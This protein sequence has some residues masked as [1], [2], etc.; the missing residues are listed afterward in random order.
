MSVLYVYY[1]TKCGIDTDQYVY[2]VNIRIYIKSNMTN[3]LCNTRKLKG[4]LT[5]RRCALLEKFSFTFCFSLICHS[6]V[7]TDSCL[8]LTFAPPMHGASPFAEY[9]LRYFF[10]N[11]RS[12]FTSSSL[13]KH[14][15]YQI[16]WDF[17]F[18]PWLNF[19][20]EERVTKKEG[21]LRRK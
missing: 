9:Y 14:T 5:S 15:N 10:F 7:A 6:F 16:D 18:G 17:Q 2:Y 1:L 12:V 3:V 20:P 11:S 13:P 8:S 19:Y 4:F 21:K